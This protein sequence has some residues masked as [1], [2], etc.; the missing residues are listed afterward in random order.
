MIPP[1]PVA[2]GIII[3]DRN[4]VLITQDQGRQALAACW[5]FPGGKIEPSELPYDALC[6]ELREELGMEVISAT[7]WF[8]L[9]YEYPERAVLLD[10]WQ[11]H[12]YL[13]E[14]TPL[15]G[16]LMHWCPL[17][18]LNDY[19]F[20]PANQEIVTKLRSEPPLFSCIGL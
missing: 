20:L 19:L 13:G 14:P 18:A 2:V 10:I 3:N 15:E 7:P 4:E 12:T 16:Q 5:G 9:P 17:S 8:A 1:L 11:V 6:R